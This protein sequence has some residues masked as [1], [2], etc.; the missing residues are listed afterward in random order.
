MAKYAVYFMLLLTTF[1]SFTSA[2]IPI[3]KRPLGFPYGPDGQSQVQLHAFLD[4]ACPDS[5]AA[6]PV[7]QEVADHY[8]VSNLRLT[9]IMFPLPYHRAAWLSTQVS[10]I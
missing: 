1:L 4:L 9:A 5:K 8:E 2:Q 3:P 10:F 6:F 7:L